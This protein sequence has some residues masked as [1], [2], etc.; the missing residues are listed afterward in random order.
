M[1]WE[2]AHLRRDLGAR[3]PPRNREP[4]IRL[5]ELAPA[6]DQGAHRLRQEGLGSN[7]VA[8]VGYSSKMIE[9]SAKRAVAERA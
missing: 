6:L 1:L 7:A 4:W 2:D 9:M 8:S 5:M 3:P